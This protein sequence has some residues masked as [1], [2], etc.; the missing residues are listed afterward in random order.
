MINKRSKSPTTLEPNEFQHVIMSNHVVKDNLNEQI[1]A[2]Y[3]QMKID[4]RHKS[5]LNF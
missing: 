4:C 5:F 3:H 1:H 2:I